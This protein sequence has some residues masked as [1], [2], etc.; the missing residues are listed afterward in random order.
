MWAWIGSKPPKWE[1]SASKRL[2][3]SSKVKAQATHAGRSFMV[4]EALAEGRDRAA[5]FRRGMVNVRYL[6]LVNTIQELKNR[7]PRW[8]RPG[9]VLTRP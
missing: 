4:K 3:L 2:P 7:A 5:R 6:E 1:W 9:R 8:R